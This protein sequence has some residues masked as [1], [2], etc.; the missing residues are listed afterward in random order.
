MG[1]I[2]DMHGGEVRSI[3]GF[4]GKTYGRRLLEELDICGKII[5]K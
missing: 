5:F 2:C 4:S 3:Q 1:G